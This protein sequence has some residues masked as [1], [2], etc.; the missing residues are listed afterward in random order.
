M[1]TQYF[2]RMIEEIYSAFGRK[3]PERDSA[4]YRSLWR[5]VC[6]ERSVPNEAAKA[7]AYA[8]CEYDTLPS[9]LGKA[10]IREFEQWLS[11]NPQAK[12]HVHCCPDCSTDTPGFFWL[13]TA[14]GQRKLCKCACNRDPR[15]DRFTPM[16]RR[17][18]QD[19]GY[20]LS[21]PC[22]PEAANYIPPD[23]RAAIGHTEQPRKEHVRQMEAYDDASY[24]TAGNW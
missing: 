15:F 21:D 12:A 5:R 3:T 14:D 9:N 13:W 11:A 24:D 18:A 17:Q 6:E 22:A 10:I 16:T 8:L 23:F 19:A 1:D 20:L 7:I 2:Q 4:A